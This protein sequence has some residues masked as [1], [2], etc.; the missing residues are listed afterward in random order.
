MRCDL[1]LEAAEQKKEP[2]EVVIRLLTVFEAP[3]RRT[4]YGLIDVAQSGQ[5]LVAQKR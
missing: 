4:V 2:N 3:S 1:R 5:R